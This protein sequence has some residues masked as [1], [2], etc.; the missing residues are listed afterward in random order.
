MQ[1]YNPIIRTVN[2]NIDKQYSD[3]FC[4]ELDL[5]PIETITITITLDIFKL[6]RFSLSFNIGN[7]NLMYLYSLSLNY[8][9]YTNN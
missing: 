8:Y 7:E 9:Y 5:N 3:S 6:F 2:Y 4:N 1:P